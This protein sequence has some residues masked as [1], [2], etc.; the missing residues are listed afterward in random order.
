[1]VKED[2]LTWANVRMEA[3]VLDPV[4]GPD[5]TPG[6][7]RSFYTKSYK[8]LDQFDQHWYEVQYDKRQNWQCNYLWAIIIDCIINGRAAYC[9]VH[10]CN[11]PLK[12]FMR[13]FIQE[14]R[15]YVKEQK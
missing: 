2:K 1:M 11:E 14:L 5:S 7:I 12:D 13:V 8:A 6:I 15:A 10:D 9:E 3:A 4:P